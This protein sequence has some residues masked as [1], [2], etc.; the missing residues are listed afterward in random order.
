MQNFVR[1]QIALFNLNVADFPFQ[2]AFPRMLRT[3][4]LQVIA[5]VVSQYASN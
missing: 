4:L 2:N 3:S 1:E 5:R